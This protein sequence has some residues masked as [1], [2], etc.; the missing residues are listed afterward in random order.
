M[1]LRKKAIQRQL[2]EQ[3]KKLAIYR[4]E[5]V[6][7]Q[8]QKPH[9]EPCMENSPSR[10]SEGSRP[11]PKMQQPT[12]Q[13]VL[14]KVKTM[15]FPKVFGGEDEEEAKLETN[16]T[17]VEEEEESEYEDSGD[18]EEITALPPM[19]ILAAQRRREAAEL[20]KLEQIKKLEEAEKWRMVRGVDIIQVSA[21]VGA[22]F[23][24]DAGKKEKE[25]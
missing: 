9:P 18:E 15:L 22:V 21:L 6:R 8:R 19:S 3:R 16:E 25:G 2:D 10:Q 7:K 23:V 20:E 24:K 12:T 11:Q 1:P 14:R 17:N 5:E 13:R 4:L